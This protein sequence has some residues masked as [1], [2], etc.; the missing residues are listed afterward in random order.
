[1]SKLEYV[2]S[3][4]AYHIMQPFGRVNWNVLVGVW[5]FL[6]CIIVKREKQEAER[7]V[8][9]HFYKA[10]TEF[11]VCVINYEEKYGKIYSRFFTWVTREGC[12]STVGSR[13]EWW[14]WRIEETHKTADVHKNYY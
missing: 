4:V 7:D 9:S 5:E 13:E 8:I 3:F 14:G 6:Q 10:M 11:C 2:G 1:M 12:G